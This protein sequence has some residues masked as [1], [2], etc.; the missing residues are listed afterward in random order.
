ML[1]NRKYESDEE[2]KKR[3]NDVFDRY[4]KIQKAKKI[5]KIKRFFKSLYMAR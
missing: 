2:M 3:V 1:I 5:N 4:Y